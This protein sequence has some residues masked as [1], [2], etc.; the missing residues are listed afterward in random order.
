MKTAAT[1]NCNC[2]LG[3]ES[4]LST[5]RPKHLKRELNSRQWPTQEQLFQRWW[6]MGAGPSRDAEFT[7]LKDFAFR[8]DYS[9]SYIR[10]LC[11]AGELPFVK[12]RGRI[13]IHMPTVLTSDFF[14][15]PA[16]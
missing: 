4:Q 2:T 13:L 6:N 11:D 3:E 12:I 9:P 5:S 10:G 14:S 1:A 8:A 15:R 16:A 7:R